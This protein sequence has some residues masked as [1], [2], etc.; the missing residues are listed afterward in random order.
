MPNNKQEKSGTNNKPKRKLYHYLLVIVAVAIAYGLAVVGM[1]MQGQ[2]DDLHKAL[3]GETRPTLSPEYFIGK[4]SKAYKAARKIPHIL[5]KIYCYCHCQ[6]TA[7]HKSLLT[8][9]IDKHGENCEICIIEAVKAYD[10]YKKG[11]KTD[12][13]VRKVQ[14]DI[15]SRVR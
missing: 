8:C 6:K 4:T 10:L 12:K 15:T 9:Y 3:G 13:I 7:G 1:N 14:A 2:D 11:Y 5:D